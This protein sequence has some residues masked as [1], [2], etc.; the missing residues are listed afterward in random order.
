MDGAQKI[1]RTRCAAKAEKITQVG[2]LNE[3]LACSA[4]PLSGKK[5]CINHINDKCGDSAA[6]LDSHVITRRQELGLD[7][8]ILTTGG[9]RKKSNI[10]IS[11]NRCTTAGMLYAIRPCGIIMGHMELLHAETCTAFVLLLIELFG[12]TPQPSQLTGVIIDRACDVHPY[13]KRIGSEG[14]EVCQY[15][16]TNLKW[17]VDRFHI[18]G[19]T[20]EQGSHHKKI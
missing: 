12:E 10:A 17:A 13:V 19:H 5:F 3:F 7:E 14:S 4:A 18:K 6:R 2:R 9:C 20:E 15:F 16:D 8:D 11:E 1:Y